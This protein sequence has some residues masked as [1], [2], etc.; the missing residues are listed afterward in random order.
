MAKRI[1]TKIGNIFCVEFDNGTKGYFQYIANDIEQMNSSVIRAFKTHYPIDQDVAIDDIVKD[2]L[3]FYAHTILRHG[4]AEN[5][6]YKI[7]KSSNIGIDELSDII[8]GNAQEVKVISPT[9]IIDVDPMKNWFIWHINGKCRD[10]GSLPK[11]LHDKVEP[12]SVM[13]C[14]QIVT[15]MYRGY[16]THSLNEYGILK[17]RP[18][19]EYKSYVRY[20]TDQS[21][22]LLCFLGDNFEKKI[23]IKNGNII[24]ITRE[25]A[26]ENKLKLADRRFSDTNWRCSDFITAEDFNQVWDKQ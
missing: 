15:R 21:E 24:R 18:R 14:H 13:C 8:F 25:D 1:V 2:D 16:Y 5:A 17:R 20:K 4:I 23:I 12:G 6:W 22:I 7:G 26:I 10:I 19:P 9:E 11:R 3:A